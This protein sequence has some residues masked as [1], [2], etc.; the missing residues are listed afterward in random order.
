M[1]AAA[2]SPNKSI[3]TAARSRLVSGPRG[4]VGSDAVADENVSVVATFPETSHKPI[5]YPAAL[6]KSAADPADKAFLEALSAA[7]ADAKFAEQ[8]FV[9]LN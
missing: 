1:A 9:V 4:A 6:L 2:R 5:T 8:G 7:P 3:S